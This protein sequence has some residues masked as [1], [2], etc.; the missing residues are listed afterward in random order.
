MKDYGSRVTEVV[1]ELIKFEKFNKRTKQNSP[2]I[3]MS[4]SDVHPR[5][6][7][8]F[9]RNMLMLRRIKSIHKICSGILIPCHMTVSFD[10]NI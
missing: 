8:M 10:I 7:K 4:M 6:N 1:A 9:K 3:H 5:G 2:Y